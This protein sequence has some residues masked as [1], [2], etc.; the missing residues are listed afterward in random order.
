MENFL[1]ELYR[2][3][4][5][6]R[7]PVGLTALS[8]KLGVSPAAVAQMSVRLSGEGWIQRRGRQGISLA[9]KGRANA[10]LLIRRHRLAERF[11]TDLLGLSLEQAHIEAHRFEHVISDEVDRRLDA[12]LHHPERCPCG[13]PIPTENGKIQSD[14]DLMPL[15]ALP[16]GR[17]A[18]IVRLSE[19]DSRILRY[20]ETLR[21]LPGVRVTVL[22]RAPFG[23]PLT[24]QAGAGKRSIGAEVAS[25]IFVRPAP[26]PRGPRARV[27]PVPR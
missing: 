15:D 4:D 19:D 12:L 22:E 25:R 7:D 14:A 27:P 9:P 20:L 11:F 2:L 3:Q 6:R 13:H 10:L 5:G 1:Q 8:R 26:N 18:E 21:L 17:N 23:G 24:L 16:P